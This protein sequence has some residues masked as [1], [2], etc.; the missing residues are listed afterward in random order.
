MDF[1]RLVLALPVLVLPTFAQE[2]LDPPLKDWQ[3]AHNWSPPPASAERI[4]QLRGDRTHSRS[5]AMESPS[6]VTTAANT[7]GAISGALT[8]I[9]V[10]PCRL[11]DTRTSQGQTGAWGPP[12]LGSFVQRSFDIPANPNCGI[13]NTAVAYSLNF[14][15]VP[16]PSGPVSFL[17]A[18]PKGQAFPGTSTL[19]DTTPGAVLANAAIVPAG[20]NGGITVVAGNTTDLLIDINGY[21]G[22]EA[23]AKALGSFINSNGTPV[24]L[25]AGAMVTH[26]ATGSYTITFPTGSFA[27]L[28]VPVAS[29]VNQN[30]VALQTF[31][32]TFNGDGSAT[33]QLNW[34]TPGTATGVDTS[35]SLIMVQN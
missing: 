22:A 7:V 6:A 31:N 1:R 26:G 25:P 35:F 2:L 14:T 15:V 23:G 16:P 20:T 12:A 4:R 18:W 21:F 29:A 3:V 33:V 34:V 19:N 9:A 27:T 24:N 5:A 13:P 17:S 11:V 10:T 8:F 30:A 32:L 28:P